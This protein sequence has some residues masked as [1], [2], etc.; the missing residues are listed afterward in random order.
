VYI[1]IY[2][3]YNSFFFFL[4]LKRVPMRGEKDQ[5][6]CISSIIF[7]P[8]KNLG[9]NE[10]KNLKSPHPPHKKYS[11]K[12]R[13]KSY[14]TTT[15]NSLISHHTSEIYIYIYTS[16]CRNCIRNCR[17]ILMLYIYSYIIYNMW[18]GSNSLLFLTFFLSSP[19]KGLN[20]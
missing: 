19:K 17:F 13:R 6:M 3:K 9:K 1:H 20:S 11:S 16:S 7:C 10:R 2:T 5:I 8:N 4:N 12:K 14:T 15:T 18:A